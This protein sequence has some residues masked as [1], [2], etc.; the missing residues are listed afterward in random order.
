MT[1]CLLNLSAVVAL[2][3]IALTACAA[4]SATPPPDATAAPAT[5]TAASTATSVPA[6]TTAAPTVLSEPPATSARPSALDK[7]GFDFPLP[8]GAVQTLVTADLAFYEV[9]GAKL[10]D[11]IAFYKERI[12]AF[13]LTYSET[14]SLGSEGF[15]DLA[16][17]GPSLTVSISLTEKQ[18]TIQMIV[19]SF[20]RRSR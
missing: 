16:F 3:S 1:R 10:D 9:P 14:D 5:T 13:G 15:A 17:V 6:A 2:L 12:P 11:V 8:K 18:G 7:L 20:E 19:S 4:S